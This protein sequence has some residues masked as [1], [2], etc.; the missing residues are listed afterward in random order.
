MRDKAEE[1]LELHFGSDYWK[2][3]DEPYFE[4]IINA[5]INLN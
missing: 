1:I 2:I 4:N 5:M 3:K